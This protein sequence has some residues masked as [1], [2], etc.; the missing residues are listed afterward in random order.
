LLILLPIIE[1]LS[2]YENSRS[3]TGSGV[4]GVHEYLSS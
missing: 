1:Q 2:I 3:M 4:T